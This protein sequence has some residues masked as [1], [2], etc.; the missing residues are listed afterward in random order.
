MKLGARHA[1][2]VDGQNANRIEI[3]IKSTYVLERQGGDVVL[4]MKRNAVERT[5]KK[6]LLILN[7]DYTEFDKI[8]K[9]YE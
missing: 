4:E 7:K 3:E 8:I 9:D 1:E 2:R 5:G 6:Y